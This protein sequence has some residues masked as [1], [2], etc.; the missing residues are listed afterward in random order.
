VFVK[1]QKQ[2]RSF[3]DEQKLKGAH[4]LLSERELAKLMNCSRMTVSKALAHLAGEGLVERRHGSGTYIV[5][6]YPENRTFTIGIGLRKPFHSSEQHFSKMVRELSRSAE[7]QKLT[8]QIFDD[9]SRQF[10]AQPNTNSLVRS[11]ES[12]IV[13]GVLLISRMPVEIVGLLQMKQV[14]LALVNSNAEGYMNVPTVCCDYFTAGFL[15]AEHLIKMGHRRFGYVRYS[16]DDHPEWRMH[17]SG[18]QCALRAYDLPPFP[19]ERIGLFSSSTAAM[20]EQLQSFMDLH[21]PTAFFARNDITASSLY[22]SLVNLGLRVP[23]D[24]SL[25][26]QGNYA[27]AG[28]PETPLTTV[29]CKLDLACRK[30]LELIRKL[31]CGEKHVE[32]MT[33]IH[34]EL[35]VRDSVARIET[36]GA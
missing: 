13:D 8:L 11:V 18:I 3:V 30:G 29:D 9:L 36:G 27:W 4:R 1:V 20:T 21:K 15:A 23:N 10:Q 17:I 25:I 22:R 5:E 12:D 35:I 19:R 34:P 32:R 6:N 24:I 2:L 33:T 28:Q 31:V 16:T 7:P 26:G 14:P